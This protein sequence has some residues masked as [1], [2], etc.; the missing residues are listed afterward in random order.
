MSSLTS[1]API[2]HQHHGP[3]P[4]REFYEKAGLAEYLFIK[5]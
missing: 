5:M 1:L 3:T 4:H 2:Q